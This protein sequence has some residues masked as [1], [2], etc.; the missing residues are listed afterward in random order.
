MRSLTSTNGGWL[1]NPTAAGLIPLLLLTS[2]PGCTA[3]HLPDWSSVQT[4][5]ADTRMEVTLYKDRTPSGVGQK[6]RGR[7]L[8]TIDN[9]VTLELTERYYRDGQIQ[10][11]QHLRSPTQAQGLTAVARSG[12]GQGR[13]ADRFQVTRNSRLRDHCSPS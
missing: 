7:V 1:R 10:T 11:L 3:R 6:F 9:S 12:D 4:V 8:S 5:K 2:L 13:W